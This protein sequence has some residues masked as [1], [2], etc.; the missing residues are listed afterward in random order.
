MK[1]GEYDVPA[2]VIK[3][4]LTNNRILLLALSTT[5]RPFA[6]GSWKWHLWGGKKGAM[7]KTAMRNCGLSWPSSCLLRFP[8]SSSCFLGSRRIITLPWKNPVRTQTNRSIN[9]GGPCPA[10]YPAVINFE[11]H[12]DKHKV[13][14][15]LNK[16]TAKKRTQNKQEESSHDVFATKIQKVVSGKEICEVVVSTSLLNVSTKLSGWEADPVIS[17]RKEIDETV[18]GTS[19][20]DV[21][22]HNTTQLPTLPRIV[23][24]E[25][26][27]KIQ[28]AYRFDSTLK[29]RKKKMRKH[30]HRK[31]LRAT[32]FERKKL[33]KA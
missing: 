13:L 31:R 11:G 14:G 32:L 8:T 5:F 2:V 25:E 33:K 18:N 30:Q 9:V 17:L 20:P 15:G 16:K 10:V 7:R 29:K 23:P 1:A 3:D 6:S 21:N 28:D 22:K 19:I 26:D 12:N 24:T 27:K 4:Q